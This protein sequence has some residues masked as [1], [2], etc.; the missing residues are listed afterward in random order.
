MSRF[1]PLLHLKVGLGVWGDDTARESP[2]SFYNQVQQQREVGSQQHEEQQYNE[3]DSGFVQPKINEKKDK[4][5]KRAEEKKRAREREAKRAAAAASDY[6]PGMEGSVRPNDVPAAVVEDYTDD[7]NVPTQ[8][9][10]YVRILM[11]GMF[12]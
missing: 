6:I 7:N 10:S 9:W 12:F 5:A 2:N 4:K 11:D 1:C 3:D 8:Q